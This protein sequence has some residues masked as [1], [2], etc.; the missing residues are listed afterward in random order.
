MKEALKLL[1]SLSL[2]GT[3][4]MLFV[5]L[6]KPL[7]RNRLSRRWQY[8]IWLVVALRF[9]LPFSSGHTFSNILFEKAESLFAAGS[10]AWDITA[11]TGGTAEAAGTVGADSTVGTAAA[12]GLNEAV[13]ENGA[14]ALP[15]ALYSSQP[16]SQPQN[17]AE[18]S[19]LAT[20]TPCIFYIWLAVAMILFLRRIAIYHNFLHSVKASGTQVSDEETLNLLAECAERQKVGRKV[21]LYTNPLISSPV[22][23]GIFHP[24]ILL[25]A[26][27]KDTGDAAYGE[28]LAYIFTHELVHCRRQDMLYKWFIQ[29]VLCIHW[30][31]PFV[32]LLEKEAGKACELACDEAVIQPL[33]HA[34]R[35]AYGNTLLAAVRT[36]VC[37]SSLTAVSL[38][39]DAEE[40]KERLGA[41]M[42]FRKSTK[43]MAMLTLLAT[44]VV[45]IVFGALGAYAKSDVADAADTA[46]RAQI[47]YPW[48]EEDEPTNHTPSDKDILLENNIFCEFDKDV[49]Y[50]YADGADQ[51]NK[52]N[53]SFT[54]GTLG[55]IL[56]R[57][58]SYAALGPFAVTESEN[59]MKDITDLCGEMT[60]YG[61]LTEEEADCILILAGKIRENF[62]Y[63]EQTGIHAENEYTYVHRSYYQDSYIIGLGWNLSD[64]TWPDYQAEQVEIRLADGT[65]M[66]LY[67]SE[68]AA[69]YADNPGVLAAA[70]KLI[71]ALKESVPE[72][73][74]A[75]EAPLIT[76]IRQE[77]TDS[78]ATLAEKAIESGDVS[79]F[80][81]LFPALEYAEQERF[82]ELLYADDNITFFKGIIPF[83][84]EDLFL[85]FLDRSAADGKTAFLNALSTADNFPE[86][87][88]DFVTSP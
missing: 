58:D 74:P 30:F 8:Y 72:G 11:G 7:Y 26:G 45:C 51:K 12:F 70:V 66:N 29:L 55:V 35:K 81:Q 62:L 41:I 79:G 16:M 48:S 82:C 24:A 25:P 4:L 9:L 88:I 21:K 28:K 2:S 84:D 76:G 78:L 18:S 83:L 14:A 56:V 3:L 42:K 60:G 43:R 20:V 10:T 61:S 73:Y 87:R 39:E 15:K 57:K 22:L 40:L 49:F 67:F 27:E 46:T 59:F 6:A 5:F 23:T 69:E 65:A 17:T 33:D 47:L 75:L 50:I 85:R 34:G 44:F 77:G 54:E 53:V 32:R 52:P 86:S 1:L 38:K 13:P 36:E 68:D 71:S 31:N 63:P 37:G 80:S 19:P 64:E